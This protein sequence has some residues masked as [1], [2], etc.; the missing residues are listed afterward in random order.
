M[1][2]YTFDERPEFVEVFDSSGSQVGTFKRVLRKSVSVTALQILAGGQ[3]LMIDEGSASGGITGYYDVTVDGAAV[4]DGVADDKAAIEA[5]LV[6]VASDGR[7]VYF[8][9]GTYRS[10]GSITITQPVDLIGLGGAGID[11]A[12]Q[13]APKSRI[14]FDDGGGFIFGTGSRGFSVDKLGIEQ[15]TNLEGGATDGVTILEK[16]VF[17]DVTV[18][19]FGGDGFAIADAL[20]N[21]VT[22][23]QWYNCW[24]YNCAKGYSVETGNQYISGGAVY[25]C[26]EQGVFIA[27]VFGC[28]VSGV[29]LRGCN[30]GGVAFQ[31]TG[32]VGDEN[33][34]GQHFAIGCGVSGGNGSI[35][36]GA[37]S[38]WMGGA[39]GGGFHVSSAGLMFQEQDN[40][41]PINVV[42]AAGG[43]TVQSALGVRGSAQT[44]YQWQ[45]SDDANEWRQYYDETVGYEK[46]ATRYMG[47]VTEAYALTHLNHVQGAGKMAFPQGFVL[48]ASANGRIITSG[49][50]APAGASTRPTGLWWQG[51]IVYNNTPT[52]GGVLCW[53]C[54]V[55]GNPGTWETVSVNPTAASSQV[56]VQVVA[57]SQASS[58][59]PNGVSYVPMSHGVDEYISFQITAMQTG[60]LE[61]SALYSMSAAEANDVRLRLDT[62]VLGAGDDPTTSVT[63]GTAFTLTPGSDTLAHVL[64]SGDSADFSIAVTAGDTVYC[65]LY[66]LGTSILDTHTGDMRVIQLQVQ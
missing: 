18:R 15:G 52:A 17:R 1:P 10:S 4:G 66:R 13:L 23:T 63:T 43:I 5:A 45:S 14:S 42:N 61:V 31:L 16:G 32:P 20:G 9:P 58:V 11:D 33:G 59:L 35:L 19:Y 55:D 47:I 28:T 39:S 36:I 65:S 56:A 37:S 48:G 3:V 51:D 30:P 41:S 2:N 25:N 64:D 46:W 34:Q 62:L 53:V 60:T 29:K 7:S 8:P 44:A 50:A 24:I 26:R 49:N 40:C 38:M 57:S 6:A 22:E 54:I 21:E 27:N 12:G